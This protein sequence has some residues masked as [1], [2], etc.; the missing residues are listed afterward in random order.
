MNTSKSFHRAFKIII[1]QTHYKNVINSVP[2]GFAMQ[3]LDA[4]PNAAAIN[5]VWPHRDSDSEMFVYGMIKYYGGLGL[6]PID[7]SAQP[8]S[9]VIMNEFQGMGLLQTAAKERCKGY[10]S[11][12]VKAFCKMVAI[13]HGSDILAF[14]I[15]SNVAS[16]QL[17]LGLGFR[18]AGHCMYLDYKCN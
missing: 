8:V 2:D 1:K 13:E 17:M 7:R 15:D 14:V 6:F 16:N 11:L 10:A 18:V 3:S 5:A 12:V 4:D 9:W